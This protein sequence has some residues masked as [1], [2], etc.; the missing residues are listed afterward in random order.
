[1]KV[2][3]TFIEGS[4]SPSKHAHIETKEYF[5]ERGYK[6]IMP[7]QSKRHTQKFLRRK[8]PL[9]LTTETLKQLRTVQSQQQLSNSFRRV[10]LRDGT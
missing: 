1:M 5:K 6:E 3:Q 8:F 9:V 2:L 4:I 7:Y 10:F